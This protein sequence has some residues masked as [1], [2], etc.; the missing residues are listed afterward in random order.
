MAKNKQNTKKQK[1]KKR[2]S[3]QKREIGHNELRR[4][5]PQ[6]LQIARGLRASKAAHMIAP[7]IGPKIWGHTQIPEISILQQIVAIDSLGTI[8]LSTLSLTPST[9]SNWAAL[10]A[11]FDEYRPIRGHVQWTSSCPYE[12]N[13]VASTECP[14]VRMYGYI[15]YDDAVAPG[16]FSTAYEFIDTGKPFSSSTPHLDWFFHFAFQP[17]QAWVTT[18]SPTSPAYFKYCI[19]ASA[20]GYELGIFRVIM[21][22]QFRQVQ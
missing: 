17:D 14:P 18:A 2:Q 22:F 9:A 16:S 11:L 10:T 1:N 7:M 15:D 8:Q 6:V 21:T 13:F 12:R 4:L 19:D 5:D 3:K 20:S